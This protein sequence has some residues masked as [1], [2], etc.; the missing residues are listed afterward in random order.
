MASYFVHKLCSQL[1]D[2]EGTTLLDVGT[3][4]AILAMLAHHHGV[5]QIVGLEIDPEARRVARE[6][7][8]RNNMEEIEIRDEPLEEL[9]D[10]FDIVVANIIDGV[11]IKLREELL[12]ALNP[13]GHIFLTGILQEREEHFF[14]RFIE[15]SGLQVVRRI[16]EEEW[17]GYWLKRDHSK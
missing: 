3:G 6:N 2:A 1:Q 12:Q 15:D 5:R 11:L 10:T 16:E 7:I 9:H 4:T 13:G 14:N 17:V 8:A